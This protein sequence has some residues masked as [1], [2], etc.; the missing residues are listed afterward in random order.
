MEYNSLHFLIMRINSDTPENAS[1]G[2][3]NEIA[4]TIATENLGLALGMVSKNLYSNPLGSFIREITS[5]AVDAHVDVNEKAPVMVHFYKEDDSYYI[6]FKDNGSGM[7]PDV[8]KNIYMSWFNSDKRGTNKKIGGWGLGSKSPLAY[9][10][11]FEI[12]TRVDGTKWHYILANA[13]PVPTSTFLLTEPTTQGNGTTIKVEVKEEDDWKLHNEC[14]NQLAYFNNVYVKNDVYFYDNS[15]KIYESDLYQIRTGNRPFGKQMHIVLGQV[16]YPINW[17]TLGLDAV[18]IP[19]AL[20][21]NIGE[22]DVTLS[23]EE[24]NY[25]DEVKETITNRIEVVRNEILSKYK[26][27]LK[28]DDLFE[29]I[30]LVK[31][32]NLPK[33]K[34]KDIELDINID[35]EISFTPFDNIKIKKDDINILFSIYNV[36]KVSKA[37]KVDLNSNSSYEYYR[38][39]RHPETCYMVNNNISYFDLQYIQNGYLFK[40]R[41]IT[42]RIFKN[43]AESLNLYSYKDIKNEH[44]HIVN[45]IPILKLGASKT[46]HKVINYIHNYIKYYIKSLE[47]Q[48]P[49][50]F[51]D[52][53]KEQQ[54]LKKEETKG[55]ITY[56]NIH[57]N[58]TKIKLTKLIEDY[59]FVFYINK[60]LNKEH[61]Y[62]YNCL[63]DLTYNKFKK[64]TLFIIVAPTVLNKIKKFNNIIPVETLLKVKSIRHTL[65]RLRLNKRMNVVKNYKET[66]FKFSTKYTNLYRTVNRYL[67]GRYEFSS[68]IPYDNKNS[69]LF[70]IDLLEYFK[71]EIDKFPSKYFLNQENISKLENFT[72]DIEIL[73]YV[74]NYIPH[75]ELTKLIK[76]YNIKGLDYN[77]Y[78]K[79]SKI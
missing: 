29:Y 71:E 43:I 13:E 23:R 28:F 60:N 52:N 16:C 59:K 22:L 38:L 67:S 31:N 20:K 49:Q 7:T 11:S 47:G 54:R 10:D 56:Y 33:Y 18:N 12:I 45:S 42:K 75:N 64:D 61:I 63:Y 8:F 79:H 53:I 72:K 74:T 5:N 19:V 51:I 57:N 37:R 35:H 40:K 41:K 68:H 48:A 17:N 24:I 4:S 1:I 55:E 73:R 39:H 32:G 76:K 25:T 70:E 2:D 65:L 69:K 62:A 15:F 58:R 44:G 6:E 34:I 77:F 30:R 26:D 14:R 36:S 78:N 3:F 46:V 27:Q 21:F 9:Q 50:E 66:I